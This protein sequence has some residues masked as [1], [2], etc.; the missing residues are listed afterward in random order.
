MIPSF[1]ALSTIKQVKDACCS[2]QG[3]GDSSW[4]ALCCELRERPRRMKC[5]RSARSAEFGAENQTVTRGAVSLLVNRPSRY[6]STHRDEQQDDDPTPKHSE[7]A[8]QR[9]SL[10]QVRCNSS[11]YPGPGPSNSHQS[12][13]LEQV[14]NFCQNPTIWWNYINNSLVTSTLTLGKR[15]FKTGKES[16][17]LCRLPLHCS[18]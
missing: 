13:P 2:S 6:R 9:S 14:L 16:T 18:P 5:A 15:I 12:W 7:P 17:P 11:Q 10:A 8:L 1:G 3:N 4:T